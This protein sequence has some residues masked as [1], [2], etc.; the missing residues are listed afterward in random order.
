M[1]EVTDFQTHKKY[2]IPGIELR[3]NILE[4]QSFRNI[5]KSAHFPHHSREG[6]TW[7]S[8]VGNK[9]RREIIEFPYYLQ[10]IDKSLK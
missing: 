7:D 1:N 8:D 2:S 4:K 5:L 6:W 9:G 10:P 3:K